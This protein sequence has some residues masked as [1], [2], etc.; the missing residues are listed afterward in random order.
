MKTR[1][2]FSMLRAL[3]LALVIFM[4]LMFG[5][6]R[7]SSAYTLDTTPPP[8]THVTGMWWNPSESGW[9][10]TFT[11]QAN[12]IFV[13]LYTYDSTGTARWYVVSSCLVSG[14]GCTGDFYSV[15]GGSAPTVPWNPTLMP[16]KVG[17]F[18]A[19]FTDVNNGSIAY[20]INGVNGA[21]QITRLTWDRA[22]PPASPVAWEKS[23][24]LNVGLPAGIA[25]YRGAAVDSSSPLRAFYATLDPVQNPNV[26]WN[27]A[28]VAP[29]SKTP[30]EF[31][32]S[33]PKRTY[34]T[35]NG[36]YFGASAINQSFSLIVKN[37]ALAAAGVKQLTR[38]A[39]NFFPTRAAF[40][41]MAGGEIV[42]TWAYPVG[43]TNTLTRYPLPSPNDSA[44]APL[45]VPDASF[46]AGGQTWNPIK[47]MGGGPLL[48]KNATK[49]I[50][51]TEEIFD[52][53]S[54]INANGVAPR[55]AVAKL[56]DGKL[57]LMVIDGRS[58]ASRGVTLSELADILLNL[59]ATDAINLD[60]G[61]SSTMVINGA[62]VNSP[63]DGTQRSI[64]SVL[65]FKD[66]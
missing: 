60:G 23:A 25:V 57:V 10:I 22:T 40:G 28:S 63:S 24:D 17:V 5:V 33:E 55:T 39:Q 45:P 35:V 53:A 58:A 6:P 32:Q 42:A 19:K 66:R 61:G 20:S 50:T 48:I 62:V 37:S 64:P 9:G 11:Q 15:Q 7:A 51:A 16:T 2:T 13:A 47:A 34:V 3:I 38:N 46:P 12:I 54:G 18:T 21:K 8:P 44:K 27:V 4:A 56:S 29:G 36:G 41:E 1:S 49:A 43:T 65:M 30:L 14:D 59:G 31:A 26:E 52:A